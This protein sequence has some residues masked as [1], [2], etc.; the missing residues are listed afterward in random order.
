MIYRLI[1]F[2]LLFSVEGFAQGVKTDTV[3]RGHY[4]PLDSNVMSCKIEITPFG[5]KLQMTTISGN[6]IPD[7][8][9]SAI[10]RLEKGSVVVY[11]E[12]TVLNNGIAVKAPTVRYIVGNKNTGV[13]KRDPSYPDTLT[14]KEIGSIILDP[15]VHS[16][17][18]SWTNGGS[19][20][21]YAITG[22]GIFGEART[23]IEA[24]PSGTRVWIENIRYIDERKL[25]DEVHVVR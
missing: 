13:V 23:A 22:N 5:K 17:H 12:I 3:Q 14:A 25:P 8:T 6:K 11:S 21:D 2:I 18:V 20:S 10:S 1:I 9:I 24:L 16:F 4:I 15:R 7:T 19:Y